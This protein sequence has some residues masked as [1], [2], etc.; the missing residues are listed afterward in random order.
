MSRLTSDAEGVYAIAVTPF[1]DDGALDLESIDRLVDFYRRAG[2]SGITVLGMMGEAPKLTL[3]ESK[4]VVSRFIACSSGLP[5]IVGVSAP[6]LAAM[7]ELTETVTGIGAAG[8]MVA[9]PPSLKTDD[10]L[11]SYY[12]LVGETL[13]DVPLVVQ[14]YPLGTGVIMS[15]SALLRI[16]ASVPSVVMLKHE[17]WPG[18]GKIASI[19]E[20]EKSGA[21][22]VS[23]LTG[24][25]G[26]FLTEELWR[27]ADGA[28]T[29]FACPEMMVGVTARHA[30][31]DAEGAADLFDV[32]LPLV[33]YEQQPGV[34]LAV[35][36]YVLAKRGAM[37]SA[38][39]R[40]PGQRLSPA[41][42]TDVERLLTRQER[43]L[44]EI[45]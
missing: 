4:Q 23:V 41:D 7:R 42:I 5:V 24:N 25:G 28:M 34:G 20:A 9:P 44:N 39:L 22:R 14:D 37:A 32:Y 31:G 29:G 15:V 45:S 21:R 13:Q 8:V 11:V 36:K 19:R 10:Q 33:R 26:L 3:E 40:R 43:R 35:R 38:A 17:D 2:V 1:T 30:A 6:G 16:F 18:L 27:G 12:E